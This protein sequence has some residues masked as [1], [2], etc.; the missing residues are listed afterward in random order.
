MRRKKL[1]LLSLLLVLILSA[2]QSSGEEASS[3]NSAGEMDLLFGT[4]H[5]TTHHAHENVYQPWVDLL[6]EKTDGKIEA[7]LH[8]NSTLGSQSSTLE[9]IGSGAYDVGM[10][11][12]P[13]YV[14]SPWFP[15]NIASLPFAFN[16]VDAAHNVT[17]EFAEKYHQE[18]AFKDVVLM[19]F[20]NTDPYVITSKVPIETVED[21]KGLQIHVPS[22]LVADV[23]EGWGATPVTMEVAEVYQALDRGVLDATIYTPVGAAGW[24]WYEI[25]PYVTNIGISS[26]PIA[27]VMNR[28]VYESIPNDLKEVF[29]NE[30]M[31]F[32]PQALRDSYVNEVDNAFGN[33]SEGIEGKGRIIEVDPEE[34]KK[35]I[36]PAES[37]WKDWENE[38]NEKGY[39]GTK[40]VEDFKSM[41]NEE[42][43][44]IPF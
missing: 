37:V 30:L 1:L 7:S 41:I 36:A 16:N 38:A 44:E 34:Q 25:A 17:R 43:I 26:S 15:Y 23:V 21:T 42:G 27:M 14:D 3:S 19:G 10:V 35:F 6:S 32:M 40:M 28:N 4:L 9:D 31:D 8:P 2:C 5:P 20:S 33:I 29:D 24:K 13:E 11:V 18:D 22:K 12:V 39:D